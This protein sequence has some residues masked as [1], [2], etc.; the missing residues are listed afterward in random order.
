MS[1]TRLP[2]F[3]PAAQ[4]HVRNPP[5]A[6]GQVFGPVPRSLLTPH[7]IRQALAQAKAACLPTDHDD[8]PGVLP[9]SQ[10]VQAAVLVPLVAR[11]GGHHVMLTRRTSHLR[12]HAGQISFPGGRRDADDASVLHTALREA[13][14]ETG[15]PADAVEV[16]GQLPE[17]LTGTGFVITPIVARVEPPAAWSPDPFEVEQVFEVPLEF[18]MDPANHCLHELPPGPGR[19]RYWSMPWRDQ[20]IWGATAGMLR[21]LYWRL[22]PG[23]G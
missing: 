8:S 22:G 3:D 1:P 18:L 2:S 10:P 21:R 16:L 19:R 6:A 13:H 11:E 7:D 5:D 17:Y 9:S 23:R 15:L 20:F 12:H 4:P 14:E